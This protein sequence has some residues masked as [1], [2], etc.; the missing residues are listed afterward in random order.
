MDPSGQLCLLDSHT[1]AAVIEIFGALADA[2]D[3]LVELIK[4]APHQHLKKLR[5]VFQSV[6]NYDVEAVI[7]LCQSPNRQHRYTATYLVLS[8]IKTECKKRAS[9]DR[10]AHLYDSVFTVRFRDVD[11]LIRGMAVQFVSEFIAENPVLRKMAYLKYV[12]WALNDRN[13]CVRKRGG[14]TRMGKENAGNAGRKAAPGDDFEA[15]FS[16]YPGVTPAKQRV[17]EALLPDGVWDMERIHELYKSIGAEAFRSWQLSTADLDAFVLNI[18]LFVKEH[19]VCCD[20]SPLDAR[21]GYRGPCSWS[22]EKK[23]SVR[24]LR[25]S[26]LFRRCTASSMIKMVPSNASS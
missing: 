21:P 10:I 4:A 3:D 25:L 26:L 15:F 19:S 13:N 1:P 16:K 5:T 17:L 20:S 7:A 6:D 23:S 8:Q 18:S 2:T 14:N 12:G 11:P 22:L 9:L 24:S